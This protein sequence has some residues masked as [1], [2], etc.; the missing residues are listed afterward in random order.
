MYEQKYLKYKSKYLKLKMDQV[1]GSLLEERKQI[2]YNLS[3]KLSYLSNDEILKKISA[4][5][6]TQGWGV[7]TILELDGNKIFCKQVRITDLEYQNMFDSSNLF[8]L[9]TYYNYGI[10]SA[11][12][13]CFRELLMH[14]KT[15]NWLLNDEIE[16]FPLLYHYRIMGIPNPESK[17]TKGQIEEIVNYWDSD[18]IGKYMEAK[19]DAHYYITLFIEYIPKEAF[20]WIDDSYEKNILYL[21]SMLKI[22]NFLRKKNII[23]FDAHLKN[24]LVNGQ[25]LYLSDFGL[26]YDKDFKISTREKDFYDNNTYYDYGKIIRALLKGFVDKFYQQIEKYE[27][28]YIFDGKTERMKTFS[29]MFENMDEVAKE[30]NIDENYIK[31]LRKHQRIITI[32]EKFTDDVIQNKNTIFPNEEI[33]EELIKLKII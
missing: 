7:N 31:L 21:D 22:I 15:T 30:L 4:G 16:N 6:Q 5:S 12:I 18:K 20:E 8:R 27:K 29:I 3:T 33:K 26:A 11:G 13:N 2:Y 9:P 14:I 23:H 24:T 1:G 17:F 28:K 19:N 32:F 25:I 10:K